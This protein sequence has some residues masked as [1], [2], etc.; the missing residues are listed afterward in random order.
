M[1]VLVVSE[2][3]PPVYIGGYELQCS[4]QVD[5][6]R[7]RGYQV[8]VLT[9][10]RLNPS[11][12][13]EKHV[14]RDLKYCQLDKYFIGSHFPKNKKSISWR[15]KQL[16]WAVDNRINANVTRR[17]I[18]D[19]QPELIYLW[20]ME[21]ISAAPLW[22]IHKSHIPY[23]MYISDY[24]LLDMRDRLFDRKNRFKSFYRRFLHG[25]LD[26]HSFIKPKHLIFSSGFL[27]NYYESK[28]LPF[29]SSHIIPI[30]ILPVWLMNPLSQFQQVQS[31]KHRLC[32][33]GRIVPEKGVEIS[34]RVLALLTKISDQ[35]E[36]EIIGDGEKDYLESISRLADSLNVSEKVRFIGKL[37]SA[38]VRDKYKEYSI[39]IFPSQWDEPIPLVVLEAM[40]SGVPVVAS[41]VGGIPEL[42]TNMF[43][44]ILVEANNPEAYAEG[45]LKLV[46]DPS[47]AD[48]VRKNAI[49]TVQ[50][51]FLIDSVVDQLEAYLHHVVFSNG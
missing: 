33:V 38:D 11:S 15:L 20:R 12:G 13:D 40:A 31:L 22:V 5:E 46:N 28:N 3:Y 36:L 7:N 18:H 42:I 23:L 24:W 41:N 16:S 29:T 44:G 30:G 37:P 51:K 17:V 47:F 49:H 10:D 6:L 43:N 26:M 8:E 48:S 25:V 19:F 32:F 45:I 2:F 35:F 21:Y 1:K 27:R 39:L 4:Y 14:H 9:S 34:I 50:N